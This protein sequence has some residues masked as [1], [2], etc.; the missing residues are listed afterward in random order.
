[1][2]KF[3]GEYTIGLDIGTASVGW[4]CINKDYELLEFRN[5]KAIGVNLFNSADTAEARRLKRGMRR[6]YNRRIKRIQML[7]ELFQPLINNQDFF[8]N[9]SRKLKLLK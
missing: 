3:Q 5:R 8:S 2:K 9:L 4:S 7:Q 1:M 6:R